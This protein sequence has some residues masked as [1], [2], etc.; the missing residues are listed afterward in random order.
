[1]IKT[2]VDYIIFYTGKG[3]NEDNNYLHSAKEFVAIM[4]KYFPEDVK[5]CKTLEE[6]LDWSGSYI[7]CSPKNYYKNNI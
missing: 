3:S 5:K 2:N 7:L 1:M 6:L 4:K